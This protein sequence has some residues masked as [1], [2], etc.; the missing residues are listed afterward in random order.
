MTQKQLKAEMAYHASLAPF[1]QML[2]NGI[3]TQEDHD[4]IATIL[5]QKY[6]PLF[7]GIMP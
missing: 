4:K 7:V 5:Y 1:H 3:I 2:K 6:S